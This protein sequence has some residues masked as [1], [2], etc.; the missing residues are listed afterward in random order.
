[1]KTA[2]ETINK[3]FISK[4]YKWHMQ[5]N[6]RN[7]N[8]PI[9]K[10][11]EDLNRHVSK[12]DIQMANKHMKRCS[13]LLIIREIQMKTTIRYQLT[14]VRMAIVKKSINNKCWRQCEEKGTFLYCWRECKLIDTMEN[15]MEIP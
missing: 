7:T 14:L 4:I 3:G 13:T 10:W 1:M 6:T 12:K 2:N 9:K 11:V 15:K 8:N 5:L